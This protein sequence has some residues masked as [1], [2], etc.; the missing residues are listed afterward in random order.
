MSARSWHQLGRVPSA[1]LGRSSWALYDWAN[2]PFTTLIITFI[3]PAYLQ[4]ALAKDPVAGQ[5]LW[6][7]A[8]SG[9]GLVIAVSAPF[10][11]AVADASGRRKPWIFVFTTV[12]VVGSALLWFA[13][14][15]P[16]WLA[17]SLICVAIA[18]VGFEFGVAFNNAMLPD[19]VPEE[20][21]GRLSGWAWGL[22]YAGGLAALGVTLVVFIW[23]EQPPFGLDKDAAEHVRIVGPLVAIWLAVFSL[24]LFFFTPD[25]PSSG[26]GAIEAVR[27]GLRGLGRTLGELCR[28]RTAATFLLA[29][30]VYADGLITLFAFGGVYAAGAFGLSLAEVVTF[31]IV[32]N[33]AAGAGA[34]AFA[35]VDD[36]LGSKR[37]IIVALIGLIGASSIAVA[38]T[39]LTWLWVAGIAIGLFVG[40]AQAAS[41]S[42]MARLAPVERR[43]AYFG[44]FALSGKATAFL[45]PAIVSLATSASG[46]QRIG[47]AA[48][49][50]FFAIGLL[51]LL[52]VKE[53]RK[54]RREGEGA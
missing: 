11:G 32:L 1:A 6:G 10:L 42:L 20:R 28:D 17:F 29:H 23:P 48:I 14:P 37:T 31:G 40:P 36:W 19:I 4:A 21:L 43:A 7:Y 26:R 41:R 49:I 27:S 24:P 50:A 15:S 22:G 38:A 52:P 46:S 3:F 13:V 8:I 34:A 39:S 45:G 54:A 47:L 5:S 53:P 16:A 51:L 44:L 18:N 12:C 25:H 30:M 33:V 9:S 2:S 35:W